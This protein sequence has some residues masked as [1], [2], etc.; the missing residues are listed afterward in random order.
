MSKENTATNLEKLTVDERV[1]KLEATMQTMAATLQAISLTLST[2]TI[3]SVSSSTSLVPTTPVPS[4]HIPSSTI[5]SVEVGLMKT[6]QANPIQPPYPY[7]YDSQTRCEYHNVAGHGI[8]YCATLKHR[9]QDLINESK[10]QVD[11]NEAN[12][13]P[14]ITQ[15]PLPLHDAPTMNMVA[16]NVVERPVLKNVNSWSLDELFAIL[17]DS[18]DAL[19]RVLKK[20][21]VP[22]NINTQKFGTM[23][24]AIL[25]PNDVNFTDDEI[26]IEANGNTKA[27]DIF[28]QCKM[29]NVPHVLI[30][31]GLALNVI[32]LAVLK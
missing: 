20:A 28:V 9:I 29:M 7:W 21:D 1:D 11:A 3:G 31:N 6:M 22:K 4:V 27:L 13:T 8:E 19:L 16:F 24:G 26:P 18:P 5:T 2:L 12:S 23:A 14:N 17:T 32:S 25:A 15:N 30:D 10:P